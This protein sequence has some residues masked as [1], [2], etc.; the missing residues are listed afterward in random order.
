MNALLLFYIALSS[1]Y[2]L[3]VTPGS[4]CIGLGNV[5]TV[6]DE[7]FAAFHN[8]ALID[9]NAC[10]FSI[11]RYFYGTNFLA[12]S[13]TYRNTIIGLRYM[14]YGSIQGYDEAGYLTNAFTPYSMDLVLARKV[15]PL[16]IL[17]RGFIEEIDTYHAWGI[18]GGLSL[19][20]RIQRVALGMKVENIG[21]VMNKT[22]DIPVSF[23]VGSCITLPSDFSF[24]SEVK[25]LPMEY[26][27]GLAY[28]YDALTVLLGS[29][30]IDPETHS[31][32][33]ISA[34]S[35]DIHIS[36][37]IRVAIEDYTIGYGFVYSE[38]SKAHHFTI[39]LCP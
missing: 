21:K 18:C 10:A 3:K 14:N 37:G 16:A 20:Y 36:A 4:M 9:R 26:S 17:A 5:G 30:F 32:L 22:I 33:D 28:Q 27:A 31:G 2:S 15:G 11:A 13:G 35:Q 6:V 8:P 7:G 19:F 38:Y 34:S 24:Y 29:R 1:G 39:S 25:G 12:C 23:S